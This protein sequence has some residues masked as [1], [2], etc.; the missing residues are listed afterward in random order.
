MRHNLGGE[1]SFRKAT[2]ENA[3]TFAD[4]DRGWLGA[5]VPG[6]V[7]LDLLAAGQIPPPFYGLNEAEVQ[8]VERE[9]WLYRRRFSC[10]PE[11]LDHDQVELVCEGLDTFARVFLNGQ[12]LGEA[13][14]MFRTWRWD[15]SEI[16]KEQNE[17]FVILL[18]PSRRCERLAAE[19]G[20][21]N[22]PPYN[23]RVYARKHQSASG[24]NTAPRLNTSGIWRPLYLEACNGG[25]ISDV[26]AP[27]DWPSSDRCVLQ[28]QVQIEALEA[29]PVDLTARL[30]GH[31]EDLT[32]RLSADVEPGGNLLQGKIEVQDPA[33]W[34]PAGC[35]QQNLYEL[36]VTGSLGE[37]SLEER[38]VTLGLRR[39]E[40]R[41][42][43]D[44]DGESFI[45]HVNGEPIFCRGANWVPAHSFL[46]AVDKKHYRRLLRMADAA[47]MNM[48]RVWG[49]G[50]YESDDFYEICDRLGIMVWQ[51]FPFTYGEYPDELDWFRANVRAEAEQN[52]RRLRNHPSLVL[53][54]GNNECQ[55]RA[56]KAEFHGHRLYDGVL[57]DVCDQLDPGRPYWPGSPTGAAEPNDPRSGDQ[58]FWKVW[59][60][61]HDPEAYEHFNGRFVSEFGVQSPPTIQTMKEYLPSKGRCIQSLEMEAH[62]K[63]REGTE[64]LFRLLPAFFRVP[65]SLENRVYLMQLAQ[66]ET[67]KM[68]VEH[69]RTRKFRT[70]GTL[71]WQFNDCWPGTT[72]SCVDHRLRPKALYFYATRFF[73]PLLATIHRRDGMVQ[74]T[75]VNDLQREVEA[76]LI[77]GLGEFHGKDA[78]VKEQELNLPANGVVEAAS[79]EEQDLELSDP[80]REYLWCRLIVSN[81]QVSGN[82]C[83]FRRFKHVAFPGSA[84]D[85]EVQ[86]TGEATF[87]LELESPVFAK[88]VWVRGDGVDLWVDD[89]YFDLL[90]D[91][92]VTVAARTGRAMEPDELLRRL[93]IKTVADVQN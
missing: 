56:G 39:L 3:S 60:E 9:D 20:G 64:R 76:R 86:K 37:Q 35:G 89:N 1:W 82:A 27:T 87:E 4:N 40:L 26:F 21:M 38:K 78:W 85:V 75:V 28:V 19:H 32:T 12:E 91:L 43:Q 73:A 15:V 45:I 25:R 7:H 79:L 13:D 50:I 63:E 61:W 33:L 72:W 42:E 6:C 54:C 71:F 47:H 17:L 59:S 18:S 92:P 22:A 67:V 5:E 65:S 53:W 57:R 8:W 36:S 62:Q 90:P 48:L 68:G 70:A 11:L 44:E 58:H 23:S 49:G 46:P 51:D 81:R 30:S 34:W 93:N 88:S 80:C 2:G 84:L 31:G 52:V 29:G 10:Q 41:R 14:N 16:L 83:F 74:L 55:L 24:W 69:W 77:Y 66:A